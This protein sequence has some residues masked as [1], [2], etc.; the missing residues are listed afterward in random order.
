MRDAWVYATQRGDSDGIAGGL[1]EL[2]FSPRNLNPS[3][4]LL[5]TG[6]DGAALRR[7][8]LAVVIGGGS[9][10]G[11]VRSLDELRDV[12]V[13]L[14][15]EPEQLAS[16]GTDEA[17][18]LLVLPFAKPELQA[19]V[20]RATRD[21]HGTEEGDI[22]RVGSLELNLSTYQVS[23]AGRPVGFTYMEY[24]LLKFLITHPNRGYSREALLR[25]VWGYDYYGGARTVDVHIRRV[26]A[27]LGAEHAARI[28]TI[29][30]VGYVFDLRD[31]WRGTESLPVAV[32]S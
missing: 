22:V 32:G 12:P 31:A 9:L 3:E 16:T 24:E 23:L 14:A 25:S 2:G 8:A 21:V 5:P 29:R 11:Q 17:D 10:I 19:R 26:R 20:A 30:S 7:P 1:A 6:R 4:G 15:L 27:K 13:L 28:R 18:E